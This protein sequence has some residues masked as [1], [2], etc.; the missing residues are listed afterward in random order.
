MYLKIKRII[1]I[2]LSLVL[3]ILLI[4]FFIVIIIILR[5]IGIKNPIFKQKRSGKNN[6]EFMIYKFRTMNNNNNNI[7]PFCKF[8]RTTG[9]DET[10]Q[11]FNI[12]KGEM[13]FIGPRPWIFEYSK[14]FNNK[15]MKRLDVLPGLT[16]FAQIHNCKN[17]FEKIEL[18]LEYIDKLSFKLDILIF[19][20]TI[21]IVLT[22]K[23]KEFSS[24]DINNEI[25]LLSEQTNN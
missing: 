21:K 1:D 23:K 22:G 19:L 5:L 17:I 6:K 9:I 8:L 24:T 18:D 13:S 3:L 10:L 15:Q 20:N 11:L 12:L 16:G 4:P 14:H 7:P 25:A 2:I